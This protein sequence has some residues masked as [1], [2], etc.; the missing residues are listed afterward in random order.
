MTETRMIKPRPA[1]NAREIFPRITSS[2]ELEKTIKAMQA[3]S[4]QIKVVI[5]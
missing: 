2:R 1:I 3:G 5:A 4:M